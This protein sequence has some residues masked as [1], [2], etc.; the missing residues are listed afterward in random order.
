MSK[1]KTVVDAMETALRAITGIGI[2]T[3]DKKIWSGL[4]PD[5][6]PALLLTPDKP[7]VERLA[8]AHA[9]SFD[10]HAIMQ[11]TI[12]G[13]VYDILEADSQVSLDNLL[14]DVEKAIVG[15]TALSDLT[16]EVVPTSDE[17]L[18]EWQDHYGIFTAVYAV[19]YLYNHNTP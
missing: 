17:I 6:H 11:V 10:M 9:T 2:V 7:E 14:S 3:Q 4:N 15:N 8:Y 1:R 16:V 19:E 12:E 18:T 5:D 13:L